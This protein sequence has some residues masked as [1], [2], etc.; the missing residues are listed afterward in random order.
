[1]LETVSIAGVAGLALFLAVAEGPEPRPPL[2]SPFPR[3]DVI[4]GVPVASAA[5]RCPAAPPAVRDIQSTSKFGKDRREHDSTIVDPEAEAEYQDS[6]RALTEFSRRIAS[7]ADAFAADRSKG[8][9][10]A[11]CALQWLDSW[12]EQEALLGK[13][14]STGEAV[15]KWELATLASA[16]LK[17]R[18][19]PLDPEQSARVRRWLGRVGEA[20]RSDYS[21]RQTLDSRSNNHL[22]WAA[23]AVM[24]AAIAADDGDLFD[25]SVGRFR[26][27]LAQIQADGTLPLELKRRQLALAYHN[28]ALA[29]LILLREG[30]AQNGV[31]LSSEEEQKLQ[32]LIDRV[33]SSFED[34]SL[35]AAKSGHPQDMSKVSE[36]HLAWLE[37]YYA[38]SRD[39]RALALLHEYRPM[40]FSRLGGNL[41]ALFGT[42]WAPPAAAR[43]PAENRK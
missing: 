41:T 7:L 25:W 32:R 31:R 36:T 43:R 16:F 19:A 1:M 13:V 15:R 29:P 11:R 5:A 17:I 2:N 4:V 6:T 8:G 27:A 35:I 28:F 42:D 38:R 26:H 10:N 14:N 30:S 34:P 12:A 18:N 39:R 20:V 40:T 24:A 3:A 37:P 23:W 33:L 22:N 21:Q 9:R